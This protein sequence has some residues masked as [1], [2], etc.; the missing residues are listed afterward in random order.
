MG[1]AVATYQHEDIIMQ[2]ANQYVYILH[3]EMTAA[4]REDTD[5]LSPSNLHTFHDFA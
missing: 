1:L 4:E 2:A 3:V 5:M